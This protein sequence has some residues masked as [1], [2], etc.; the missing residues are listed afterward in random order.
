MNCKAVK[1]G[2]EKKKKLYNII[3]EDIMERV[4]AK[5]SNDLKGTDNMTC[6]VVQ[7][8]KWEQFFY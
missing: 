1:E 5:F 2:L 8:K 6:V 7:F 3:Q 4:V